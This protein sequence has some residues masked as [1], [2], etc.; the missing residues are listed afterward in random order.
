MIK[1][2]DKN[3]FKNLSFDNRYFD[4]IK[5]CPVCGSDLIR[6]YKFYQ[7]SEMKKDRKGKMSK[8]KVDYS[9]IGIHS[10]SKIWFLNVK[11]ANLFSKILDLI[12][13]R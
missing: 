6:K 11:S 3:K 7:F 1:D 10:T 13:Y 8:S 2:K 12:I 5:K 4:L 9:S